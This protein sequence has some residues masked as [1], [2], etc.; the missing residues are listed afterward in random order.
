MR[1]RGKN[2]HDAFISRVISRDQKTVLVS[3]ISTL[4]L[5]N[6]PT[7]LLH[8]TSH[9]TVINYH[10]LGGITIRGCVM[11]NY[12]Y[13]PSLTATL[14][15]AQCQSEFSISHDAV[16]CLGLAKLRR[17]SDVIQG[18][19]P[20]AGGRSIS[21]VCSVFATR[22]PLELPLRALFFKLLSFSVKAPETVPH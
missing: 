13:D 19:I 4:T 15:P 5:G 9:M 1:N 18:P 8:V 3:K 12:R 20:D 2:N 16:G 21:F 7:C 14:R 17:R 22:R 11:R 6:G 10:F